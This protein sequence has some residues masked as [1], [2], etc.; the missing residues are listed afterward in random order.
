MPEFKLSKKV[1]KRCWREA[2]HCQWSKS[3]EKSWQRGFVYCGHHSFGKVFFDSLG[4]LSSRY[5][6]P[7]GCRYKLEHIVMLESEE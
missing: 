4:Y 1:C 5:H 6:V 3:Q 7:D 2:R